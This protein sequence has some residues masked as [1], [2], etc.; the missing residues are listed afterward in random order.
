MSPSKLQPALVGGAFIGILSALPIVQAG[1]CCCCLWI[2]TGGFVAA[3]L[4]QQNH[5]YPI[6]PGDGALA[7][8]WAGVTGAVVWAVMS[9]PIQTLT[10]SMQARWI[11]GLLERTPEMPDNLRDAIESMRDTQITALGVVLGFFL[12]LVLGMIFA[13]LGGTV[14]A[15]FV[16]RDAPPPGTV[17]IL[18]PDPSA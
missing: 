4:M 11:G 12:W 5:P 3:W 10:A 16:R 15:L 13:S 6:T 1:N 17:E 7:G 14:G 18:P 9:V 8:F 2:V